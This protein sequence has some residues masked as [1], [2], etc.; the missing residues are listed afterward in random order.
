ML[1]NCHIILRLKIDGLYKIKRK[2]SQLKNIFKTKKITSFES[3]IP[4]SK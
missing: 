2:I 1:L 4:I 3:T